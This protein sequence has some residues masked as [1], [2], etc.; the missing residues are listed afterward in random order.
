MFTLGVSALIIGAALA[1]YGLLGNASVPSGGS[2]AG[3]PDRILNLGLIAEQLA[4]VF[5]G[6]SMMVVGAVFVI[7]AVL[8]KS[9]NTVDGRLQGAIHYQVGRAAATDT[10]AAR[11][12][13]VLTAKSVV[14][15][16]EYDAGWMEVE[17]AALRAGWSLKR[18]GQ[19]IQMERDDGTKRR[20]VG[21][22]SAREYF[23]LPPLA[24]TKP[25]IEEGD[26]RR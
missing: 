9:L 21:M 12:S 10:A 24:S 26:V 16:A 25:Q 8:K 17:A 18:D 6:G 3:L 23:D 5:L 20:L 1:L 19:F 11:A 2:F 13:P 22:T 15:Q 14:T 4:F 7:G